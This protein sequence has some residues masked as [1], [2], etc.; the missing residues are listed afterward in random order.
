LPISRT[1]RGNRLQ[2]DFGH[3]QFRPNRAVPGR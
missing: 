3:P 1:L 2:D